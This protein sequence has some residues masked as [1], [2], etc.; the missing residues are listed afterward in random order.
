MLADSSHQ[1]TMKPLV[2][3]D[4][5]QNVRRL[6]LLGNGHDLLPIIV[7]ARTRSKVSAKCFGLLSGQRVY[8]QPRDC[9]SVFRTRFHDSRWL[10][11]DSLK[12]A[13]RQFI[14][15]SFSKA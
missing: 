5:R 11:W 8:G 6:E 2:S 12:F 15:R 1:S 3:A 9:F 10:R 4:F 14:S 13:T 7:A